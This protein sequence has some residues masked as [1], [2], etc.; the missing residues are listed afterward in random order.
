M[1]D[2][3][4][5]ARTQ[6]TAVSPEAVDP[7]VVPPG[8]QGDGDDA[9]AKMNGLLQSAL[10]AYQF[11]NEEAARQASLLAKTLYSQA[12]L[13]VSQTDLLALG[14]M[15]NLVCL[16][17]PL[18]RCTVRQTEGEFDQALLQIDG[19]LKLANQ[20]LKAVTD[21]AATPGSDPDIVNFLEPMFAVFPIMLE[22]LR[23]NLRAD[24]V[25]YE[26][27]IDEYVRLLREAVTQFQKV[28]DLPPTDNPVAIQLTGLCLMLADRLG[29]RADSF[30]KKTAPEYLAPAGKKIFIIHGQDEAKWRELAA[31]LRDR[32]HQEVLVLEE[33][34][35]SGMTVIEKFVNYAKGCCYAFALLTPDDFVK[36]G[37]ETTL[38]ARPNVLFE[39]GWFYGRFGRDRVTLC[40]KQGTNIPSDLSGIVR[41]EF[42]AQLAEKYASIEDEL[43][44]IGLLGGS[45]RASMIA[46]G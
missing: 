3:Q 36:K 46:A 27:K 23:S 7:T 5:I 14:L 15:Q 38:Q 6:A 13:A 12:K 44:R 31:L 11:Q 34:V 4:A 30:S 19:A 25:G 33:Q 35:D 40:L 39:I 24:V 17:E 16:F 18:T 10:A 28:N 21:Y 32:F 37:K 8:T 22:G 42:A 41:L 2:D 45:D 20:S 1:A 9:A 43:K 26:G 29:R